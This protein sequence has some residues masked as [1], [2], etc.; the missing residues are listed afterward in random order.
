MAASLTTEVLAGAYSAGLGVTKQ[1]FYKARGD[2]G[3]VGTAK[4][5]RKPARETRGDGFG[6]STRPEG[7]AG[8]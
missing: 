8:G 6:H 1:V 3:V 5:G 7:G 4:R 2:L